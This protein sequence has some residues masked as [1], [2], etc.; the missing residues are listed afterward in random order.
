MST[1]KNFIFNEELKV[2]HAER[3]L[4]YVDRYHSEIFL[5]LKKKLE[6]A[7]RKSLGE[8][9]KAHPP[10]PQA[11]QDAQLR[12][13]NALVE[14]TLSDSPEKIISA[15]IRGPLEVAPSLKIPLVYSHDE[16]THIIKKILITAKE[17]LKKIA[18]D[19]SEIF[20][21]EKKSQ[22]KPWF[23]ISEESDE[24][25]FQLVISNGDAETYKTLYAVRVEF[26]KTGTKTRDFDRVFLHN[27]I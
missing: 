17:A 9:K 19:W 5:D 11:V 1:L 27:L 23:K 6:A 10:K 25:R 13:P 18:N 14:L 4:L 2:N 8:L 15:R 20:T 3:Y 22:I 16:R 26:G 24:L 12:N 7:W 21:Y